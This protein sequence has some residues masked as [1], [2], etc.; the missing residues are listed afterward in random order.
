VIQSSLRYA[1]SA[2]FAALIYCSQIGVLSASP[3]TADFMNSSAACGLGLTINIDA[4]LVGSIKTLYDGAETKGKG[5]LSIQ[6]S[7][8]DLIAKAQPDASA[9]IIDKYLNCIQTT[10]A[11]PG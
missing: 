3:S 11:L 4:S 2:T 6:S 7:L 8:R 10:L 5:F 9:I 1:A